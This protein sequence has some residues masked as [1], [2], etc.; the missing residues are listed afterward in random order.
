MVKEVQR[1]T[2]KNTKVHPT[3]PTPLTAFDFPY[4]KCQPVEIKFFLL[5][6]TYLIMYA[7]YGMAYWDVLLNSPFK[8]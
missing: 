8:R 4:R 3:V 5:Y 6:K 7:L 1:F 2:L